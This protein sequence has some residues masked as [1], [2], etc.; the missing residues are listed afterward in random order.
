MRSPPPA[1]PAHIGRDARASAARPDSPRC[2]RAPTR[3]MIAFA[4]IT[5]SRAGYHAALPG[6]LLQPAP[7]RYAS[8]RGVPV[9][10]AIR[11]R[12]VASRHHKGPGVCRWRGRRVRITGVRRATAGQQ[13]HLAAMVPPEL[14]K[15]N[16]R[17][18][19]RGDGPDVYTRTESGAAGR[20]RPQD[21]PAQY[22][23]AGGAVASAGLGRAPRW[24]R[25]RGLA[26]RA[27]DD[28]TPRRR[29]AAALRWRRSAALAQVLA[30]VRAATSADAVRDAPASGYAAHDLAA[31]CTW[32]RRAAPTRRWRVPR[33]APSPHAGDPAGRC[34]LLSAARAPRPTP[35]ASC[36]AQVSLRAPVPE[37]GGARAARR[38]L[39]RS[40]AC[41]QWHSLR[42]AAARLSALLER[43]AS[44]RTC[45]CL[46]TA[47][48]R[49]AARDPRAQ[50][51]PRRRRAR[52][53][54]LADGA[55]P[56]MLPAAMASRAL[57]EHALRRRSRELL[58]RRHA[59]PR[60]LALLRRGAVEL[61]RPRRAEVLGARE[62]AERPELDVRSGG[63]EAP[64]WPGL[65]RAMCW[66]RLL[67]LAVTL[68][69]R[70]GSWP[71][72]AA[73]GAAPRSA[74]ARGQRLRRQ[75][76]RCED[77]RPLPSSRRRAAQAS[78]TPRRR[79]AAWP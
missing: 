7:P 10:G 46:S 29:S 39:A 66:P 50:G 49:R 25:R 44:R 68:A 15:K 14:S 26:R 41:P 65:A 78:H 64:R 58:L 43:H 48:A 17:C 67:D 37:G 23:C 57:L 18:G 4:P 24:R 35:I 12:H 9:A 54:P 52:P 62:P 21:L 77:R 27:H 8:L 56:G 1:A 69:A 60:G 71:Q 72:H 38:L 34:R 28:A 22:A 2:H 40:G 32:R 31:H 13:P 63:D 3:R 20:L 70:L 16:E 30:S 11:A 45:V 76:R 42:V 36:I 51:E 53:R 79:S 74:V 47:R 61:S 19:P 33:R 55:E 73:P 6:M 75:A 59:G 5:S